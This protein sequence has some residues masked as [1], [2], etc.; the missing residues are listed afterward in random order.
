M[1]CPRCSGLMIRERFEDFLD[2]SGNVFFYGLRC[3][4]CGEILDRWILKNRRH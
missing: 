1:N 2:D 3:L 4:L